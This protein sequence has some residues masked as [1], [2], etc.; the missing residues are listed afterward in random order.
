MAEAYIVA[1]VLTASE[2]G[3]GR[4]GGRH[5]RQAMG[6]GGGVAKAVI[7]VRL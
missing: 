3:R 1:A 2:A 4:A 5:G 6:E 7:V